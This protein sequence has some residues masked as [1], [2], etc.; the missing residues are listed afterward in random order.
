M[1]CDLRPKII[2]QIIIEWASNTLCPERFSCTFEVDVHSGA[3]IA[4]CENNTPAKKKLNSTTEKRQIAIDEIQQ[5]PARLRTQTE[6]QTMGDVDGQSKNLTMS[7]T[8]VCA[9]V[10]SVCSVHVRIRVRVRVYFLFSYDFSKNS[11]VLSQ[12]MPER[13]VWTSE[14]HIDTLNLNRE[15]FVPDICQDRIEQS[16]P[17][18]VNRQKRTKKNIIYS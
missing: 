13:S 17:F 1:K 14:N 6:T 10:R 16:Q 12:Q 5:W 15:Y 4:P 3:F 9:W 11:Q 7:D 8:I 18:A 2:L